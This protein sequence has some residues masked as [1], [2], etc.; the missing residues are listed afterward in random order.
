MQLI[1]VESPTKTKTINKLLG[2]GY[3]VL[4]SGGHV[5]DLPKNKMGIDIENNFEPDY[6]IP[7]KA[8]KNIK[9]LKEAVKKAEKIYLATDPDREGEAISF[10]LAKA[11]NIKEY[12]R[13]SFNEITAGAIKEALQ[14]PRKINMN[15][16]DA[17]QA[18]RVLDRLVGYKLS[19][20]LWK[21][22]ARGLSAGRVQ[23]A[24]LRLIVEKEK[25]I[26]KF[27]AEEYWSITASLLAEKGEF[28]AELKEI[29][30][31]RITKM[32]IKSEKE[33]EKLKE[34]L[35]NASYKVEKIEKKER[36]KSPLPPFT[37][38][39]M[40]QEAFNKMRY[41]SKQTMSIAQKLYEKG[42]ITYHRTDSVHLST[43]SKTEAKKIITEMLGE[44]YHKER[45]YASKGRTQEAHEAVRPAYPERK[46]E[47]VSDLTP[48]EGKLYDLIWRRFIASQMEDARF[49]GTKV[50]VG[51]GKHGL[52]AQ[53]VL[54]LFQGFTSV[55]KIKFEDEEL[56]ELEEGEAV[57]LKEINTKQHFTKPPA[58]FTEASL[59]KE[60]EKHGIGRPSTYAPI[61]STLTERN[62][63]E[64]IDKRNLKPNE[65]GII[66]SDLLAQ[67]F[68]SIVDLKFTAKM[69]DDL[70]KVASGEKKW[71]P[72][73][74]E[75]Y[76]D[77]EEN[78]K[79]KEKEIKKEDIMEEKTE[80]KCDK[81]GSDMVIKTGR[82]GKFLACKGYPECKNT[83][84]LEET[85]EEEVDPCEQ[86]GNPMKLKRSKF[87]EFYG[88]TNYPE[89][90]NIRKKD[91]K[92]GD[93]C[94]TCSEGDV[95]ERVS[96][97]GSKFYGCS[98]Y[99][100]CDFISNKK[101]TPEDSS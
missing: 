98:R 47:E 77:F 97:R 76:N 42:L 32:G 86:C 57:N 30:G 24:A 94:P 60:L 71:Q 51:T 31:K 92:T 22:V 27:V 80:E 63:I 4:A 64:K 37:T 65:I 79:K 29:E 38:S 20:F 26:G 40:Q 82:F 58:R 12:E 101:I 52:E 78:L 15:L 61:I 19:P 88:C 95:V 5:R 48:Q 34:E 84:P 93:K 59:I 35:Q 46:P 70:D 16:V 23:S 87:G 90:K 62:Y 44:E 67:H 41:S 54:L 91:N 69:E 75:F 1:L 9:E 45:N 18:R 50:K 36:K 14:N 72:L 28:L 99:P 83:K 10:H 21:K 96:K 39:T 55:Y 56:P 33:A 13:V 17:Q 100:E 3:K 74:G 49:H 43:E 53:G 11:L 73:I 8:K 66:V 89:C 2:K 6:I 81:C 7:P 68:S 85:E 25:E